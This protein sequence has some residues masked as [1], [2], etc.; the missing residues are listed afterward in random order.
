MIAIIINGASMMAQWVKNPP[1]M[2]EI[3]VQSLHQEDPLE[4]EIKI[5]RSILAW[6][7]PWTV[8]P[9]LLR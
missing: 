2:Q 1:A 3:W 4:E 9:S 6:T 8:E 5:H 7:I